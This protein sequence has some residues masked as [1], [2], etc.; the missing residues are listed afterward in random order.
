MYM[1]SPF[2]YRVPHF[3]LCVCVF[4]PTR[5]LSSSSSPS[6][7]FRFGRRGA[8]IIH[9]EVGTHPP[10]HPSPH[11]CAGVHRVKPIQTHASI[12]MYVRIYKCDREATTLITVFTPC[13]RLC[14]SAYV[15]ERKRERWRKC[16]LSHEC[17]CRLMRCDNSYHGCLD[18]LF[19][20]SPL[21]VCVCASFFSPIVLCGCH[22]GRSVA[23]EASSCSARQQYFS[24]LCLRMRLRRVCTFK[25][26]LFYF[27]PSTHSLKKHGYPVRLPPP[28][29]SLSVS[30]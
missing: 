30:V 10:I 24:S 19:S 2:F 14:S 1:G 28:P 11:K 16:A 26:P 25:R 22:R 15:R 27:C 4:F 21:S 8:P 3:Y 13:V 20:P 29:P 5:L 6:S 18:I 9:T 12:Y 23:Q 17:T 7:F